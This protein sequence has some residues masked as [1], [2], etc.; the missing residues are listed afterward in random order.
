MK[1]NASF[2]LVTD[3]NYNLNS[4]KIVT[5]EFPNQLFKTIFCF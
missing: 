3:V 4:H 5:D 1:D 2:S